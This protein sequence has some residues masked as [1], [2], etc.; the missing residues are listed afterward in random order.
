VL[1]GERE[2][3]EPVR[4]LLGRPSPCVG[5]DRELAE[6]G[7]IFQECVENDAPRAVVV[8]A[9]AGLGKS[10]LRY[11]LVARLRDRAQVWVGRGD[12]MTAGAPFDLLRQA[13]RRAYA[14]RA[15]DPIETQRKKL[16]ARVTRHVPEQARVHTT[17]FLGEMLGAAFDGA[18]RPQLRA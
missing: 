18:S 17:E 4:T 11:E 8:K 7:A 10:R 16:A 14:M 6:L 2:A 9:A 1:C 13:I 3:D 5:R 12:P 15:D